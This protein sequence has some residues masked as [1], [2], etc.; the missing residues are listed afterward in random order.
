MISKRWALGLAILASGAVACGGGTTTGPGNKKTSVKLSITSVTP[1]AVFNEG[2][3]P[4]EVKTQNGCA[5]TD[6][7]VTI[8]GTPVTASTITGTAN[9]YKFPAPPAPAGT[10]TTQPT[11]VT[12][13]ATCAKPAD[14]TT[15][16][17][18]GGNTASASFIYDPSLEPQPTITSYAP[19]GTGISVLAKM[20]VTF[21]RPMNQQSVEK[22]GNVGIQGV[23]G[24]TVYDPSTRTATFTPANQL[25][26]SNTYTCV[27]VGG[28]PGSGGVES[29][30]GK[31]LSTH[32]YPAGGASDPN[33]DSWTFT[34]RCEG[35]G[36]PWIGDI[37]AA[38]GIST[39]GNYKLFS[40]TGAPTPVGT[41]QD[42]NKTYT[43]QSG[44]LYATQPPSG[45]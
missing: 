42:Q 5:L 37:S 23:Q 30:S 43:L 38:A 32:L 1:H 6:L 22:A 39:G 44:F 19:T 40:V 29:Q 2:G 8:A 45:N 36:N 34:T 3:T 18:A 27:V 4:A 28:S 7:T 21:S 9:D 16:Y 13:A 41:A 24:A 10:S 26:Y 15:V 12:L 17:A 31:Q 33:K 11:T 35:C 14:A 20:V 25:N